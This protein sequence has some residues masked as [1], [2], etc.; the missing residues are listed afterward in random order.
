M[1]VCVWVCVYQL[2]AYPD[3]TL[4]RYPAACNLVC[5][6]KT[7][8]QSRDRR[9][10]FLSFPYSHPYPNPAKILYSHPYPFSKIETFRFKFRLSRTSLLIRKPPGSRSSNFKSQSSM[11]FNKP[12]YVVGATKLAC[13]IAEAQKSF[14]RIPLAHNHKWIMCFVFVG[15]WGRETAT[16]KVEPGG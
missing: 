10:P 11:Y 13:E 7:S 4:R 16:C 12:A 3:A 8:P 9:N 5:G 2:D 6:Q 1:R 14:C 15:I